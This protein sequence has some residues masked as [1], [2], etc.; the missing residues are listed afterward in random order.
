MFGGHRKGKRGREADNKVKVFGILTRGGK[1]TVEVVPDTT[2]EILVGLTIKKV[3]RG[4]IVYT[5]KY[6]SYDGLMYHGYRHLSVEHKD[7]FVDGKVHINGLE[8]F[9]SWAKE[10]LFKHHGIST[11][12]FPLYLKELEFRFNHRHEPIFY[13]LIEYLSDFVVELPPPPHGTG[14]QQGVISLCSPC[15]ALNFSVSTHKFFELR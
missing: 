14:S 1:A 8:G 13:T 3:R 15:I 6:R 7:K 2:A 10:R 5:D 4:S 9:W 11:K 12:N